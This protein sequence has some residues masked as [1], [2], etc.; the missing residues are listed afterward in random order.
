MTMNLLVGSS[1]ES[2]DDAAESAKPE[3][4]R[5]FADSFLATS[6]DT[7]PSV[8]TRLAA[9]FAIDETENNR[10][11]QKHDE[12][13]RPTTFAAAL[14]SQTITNEDDVSRAYAHLQTTTSEN[15]ADVLGGFAADDDGHCFLVMC[16]DATIHPTPFGVVTFGLDP[17]FPDGDIATHRLHNKGMCWAED[18][19]GKTLPPTLLFRAEWLIA[20]NPIIKINPGAFNDAAASAANPTFPGTLPPPLTAESVTTSPAPSA[21]KKNGA[22]QKKGTTADAKKS[23]PP[24]QKQPSPWAFT[25]RQ[26]SW[27]PS[28]DKRNTSS[29][30]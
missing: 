19:C 22:K 26:H 18:V 3:M 16:D 7:D 21:S 2:A 4:F 27:Y 28:S 29:L 17:F 9:S 25:Y 14:A 12:P 23:P 30:P 8:I 6:P 24:L 1:A 5:H 10:E 20:G 11:E 15:C 13:R